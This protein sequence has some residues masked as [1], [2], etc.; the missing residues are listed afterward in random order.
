MTRFQDGPAVGQ[1][2]MLKRALRFLRVVEAN[3][4]WD[5]L[6][7]PEDN[8]NSNEKLFAYEIVDKPGMMHI[9][10]GRHG[11]GFYPMACYRFVSAQPSDE[12]MRRPHLW[13]AWRKE[14]PERT[15][16]QP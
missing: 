14:Q 2:L 1:T 13:S 9:N 10:R 4:K 11:S 5:A 7:Q 3:G 12:Q 15:D 16:L 6:D 8:P